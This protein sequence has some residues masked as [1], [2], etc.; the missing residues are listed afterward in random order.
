MA[1]ILQRQIICLYLTESLVHVAT[2]LFSFGTK[3]SS[4][5]ARVTCTPVK[6]MRGE[7]WFSTKILQ[8]VFIMI[9]IGKIIII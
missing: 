5:I 8:F 3:M 4:P 7:N 1:L 2:T 9:R 6:E